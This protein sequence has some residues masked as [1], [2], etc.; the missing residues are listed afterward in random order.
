MPTVQT[1]EQTPQ[2][3]F[4]YDEGVDIAGVNR[5]LLQRASSANEEFLEGTGQPLHFTSA[6]RAPEKQEELWNNRETN[7]NG[8]VARRGNSPHE[9]GMAVDFSYNRALPLFNASETLKKKYGTMDKFFAAH[10]LDQGVIKNG[11]RIDLVHLAMT[12]DQEYFDTIDHDR[13]AKAR[14]SWGK[15]DGNHWM[16]GVGERPQQVQPAWDVSPQFMVENFGYPTMEYPVTD[17]DPIVEY[18]ATDYDPNLI[19]ANNQNGYVFDY[20]YD[21]DGNQ[22]PY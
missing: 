19:F 6:K 21:E 7:P 11:K 2:Y 22:I 18:P 15:E 3:K 16:R 10:G 14:G 5:L 12:K 8:V 4:T 17:Y 1:Q 9:A 20:D 13:Y